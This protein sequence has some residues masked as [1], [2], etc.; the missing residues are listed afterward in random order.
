M[1]AFQAKTN[2]YSPLG[3]FSPFPIVAVVHVS[4]QYPALS[5][6]NPLYERCNSSFFPRRTHAV[7]V[8]RSRQFLR[9]VGCSTL[10]NAGRF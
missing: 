1:A 9:I 6:S 5:A 10:F 7:F 2:R 8:A 4:Y 3:H